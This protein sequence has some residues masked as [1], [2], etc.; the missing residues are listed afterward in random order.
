[1]Q[2]DADRRQADDAAE[3]AAAQQAR[4]GSRGASTLKSGEPLVVADDAVADLRARGSAPATL[5]AAQMRVIDRERAAARCRRLHASAPR[6]GTTVQCARPSCAEI[7]RRDD[8]SAFEQQAVDE[9]RA[10]VGGVGRR[11]CR[12][13][14]QSPMTCA[15]T[16]LRVE[17]AGHALD[18]AG[19]CTGNRLAAA[20][21]RRRSAAASARRSRSRS[22][23]ARH[24]RCVVG[25]A[26]HQH[27]HAGAARRLQVPRGDRVAQRCEQRAAAVVRQQ[28]RHAGLPDAGIGEAAGRRRRDVDARSTG[29]PRAPRRCDRRGRRRGRRRTR[30]CSAPRP[31]R[32]SRRGREREPAAR[33]IERERA[34]HRRRELDVVGD[35]AQVD[36]LAPHFD[37]QRSRRPARTNTRSTG[38][39][40]VMKHRR[41][42]PRRRWRRRSS[43]ACSARRRSS[44]GTFVLFGQVG[45][46]GLGA[47]HVEERRVAAG[48][49]DAPPAAQV[50]R[51]HEVGRLVAGIA[52]ADRV[53]AQ[54]PQDR[55][56]RSGCCSARRASPRCALRACAR[57]ASNAPSASSARRR[58]ANARRRR[59]A[60]AGRG[61]CAASSRAA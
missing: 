43:S 4:A 44:P 40:S 45:D 48:R 17:V 11:R 55:C 21:R 37:R 57:T 49:M 13:R 54:P 58:V 41:A 5:I 25:E 19:R 7:A 46:R 27:D 8:E 29:S 9:A 61:S 20:I 2:S 39:S 47:R 35:L 38:S 53:A 10:G 22:A 32:T 1:M 28:V 31:P 14:R 6:P 15:R 52:G 3:E 26:V 36:V 34:R 51:A 24:R 30:S 12:A 60:R 33:R 59:S 23:R 56:R 16:L 18:A 42:A 50:A